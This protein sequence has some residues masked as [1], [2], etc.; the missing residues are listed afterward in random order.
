MKD[1]SDVLLIGPIACVIALVALAGAAW[2]APVS[3]EP[4]PHGSVERSR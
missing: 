4:V 3:P 2:R 1:A